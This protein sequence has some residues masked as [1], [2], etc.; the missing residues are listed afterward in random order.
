MQELRQHLSGRQLPA[1]VPAQ[2]SRGRRRP[3]GRPRAFDHAV[4]RFIAAFGAVASRTVVRRFWTHT[5]RSA[6]YGFRVLLSLRRQGLI[7]SKFVTPTSGRASRTVV[8][9]TTSGYHAI[10]RKLGQT[11]VRAWA[12]TDHRNLAATWADVFA[13]WQADGWNLLQGA[14]PFEALRA[15]AADRYRGRSL[16]GIEAV[17][18]DRVRK[19][20]SVPMP[21]PVFARPATRECWL[22]VRVW[23]ERNLRR[24]LDKLLPLRVFAPLPVLVVSGTPIDSDRLQRDLTA[25]QRARRVELALRWAPCFVAQPDPCEAPPTDQDR[26][27]SA[28]GIGVSAL[29]LPDI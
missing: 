9:L 24:W 16:T 25:W 6:T 1:R 3:P 18:R 12:S 27:L 20:P 21:C 4:L 13:D 11:H 14:A 23:P 7:E 28:H 17:M 2:R 19:A 5:G 15:T 29:P 22:V 8:R 10:G 26:Y